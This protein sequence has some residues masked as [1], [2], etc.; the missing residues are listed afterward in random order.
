MEVRELLSKYDF[1]GDDV[2]SSTKVR[3]IGVKG[4]Q[5]DIG[6]QAILRLAASAGQLHPDTRARHRRRIPDAS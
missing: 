1:P 5:S 4:D 3:C 2:P 6:E